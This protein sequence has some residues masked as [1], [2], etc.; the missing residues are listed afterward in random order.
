MALDNFL[1]SLRLEAVEEGDTD[2]EVKMT[3]FTILGFAQ[4][5]REK[6]QA[7]KFHAV[8]FLLVGSE[9]EDDEEEEEESKSGSCGG[10]RESC[11]E[12]EEEFQAL[13]LEDALERELEHI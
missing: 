1:A 5:L 8:H 6:K 3:T 4:Y 13:V 12:L 10:E 11:E 2:D 7:G 9:E